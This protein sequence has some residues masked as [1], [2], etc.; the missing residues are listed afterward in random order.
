[1]YRSSGD[2]RPVQ[3]EP[4]LVTKA[5]AAVHGME[6]GSGDEPPHGERRGVRA[7]PAVQ[8]RRQGLVQRGG[9][10]VWHVEPGENATRVPAGTRASGG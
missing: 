1:M 7:A 6:D 4:R 5:Q 8:A 10:R 9:L 3:E 2:G